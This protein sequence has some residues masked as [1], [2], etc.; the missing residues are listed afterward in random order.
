MKKH[1]FLSISITFCMI[2][3]S[4]FLVFANDSSVVDS[5][6][7]IF[8]YLDLEQLQKVDAELHNA[9]ATA[10]GE[11]TTVNEE[12]NWK[13]HYFVDEF[14]NP[15]DSAYIG[16]IKKISG[17]F[18]NTATNDSK[19]NVEFVVTSNVQIFLYEY[20][21]RQVKAGS[22]SGTSYDMVMLDTEGNKV[23]LTGVMHKN[24]DRIFITKDYIETF[25]EA[26]KKPG[27]ISLRIT[28]R[29]RSTT[30]YLF[31]FSTVGFSDIYDETLFE[32]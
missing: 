23:P 17:T 28:E 19:L 4:S 10:K 26:L 31:T 9:I 3:L 8:Q 16:N 15:T 21:D 1:I 12:S 22:Y 2:I 18:S 29:D 27:N 13:L 24:S 11:T 25:L 7:E 20:G 30:S 5:V 6:V 32:E 14:N